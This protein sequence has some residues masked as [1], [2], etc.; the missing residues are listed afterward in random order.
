MNDSVWAAVRAAWVQGVLVGGDA[1]TASTGHSAAANSAT[2]P[3][4]DMLPGSTT[5]SATLGTLA[6]TEGSGDGNGR[7]PRLGNGSVDSSSSTRSSSIAGGPSG[8]VDLSLASGSV[9]TFA[10]T[11]VEE[12][13]SVE[14][15]SVEGSEGRA[16]EA[17]RGEGSTSLVSFAPLDADSGGGGAMADPLRGASTLGSGLGRSGEDGGTEGTEESSQPTSWRRELRD[18]FD[19]VSTDRDLGTY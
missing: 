4:A 13:L 16:L 3:T 1:S 17:A 19:P 10:P 9:V 15:L 6:S 8:L 11:L 5:G 12:G 7:R 2:L 14:G 18:L